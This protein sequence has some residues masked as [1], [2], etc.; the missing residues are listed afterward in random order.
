MCVVSEIL[1]DGYKGNL[2]TIRELQLICSLSVQEAAAACLVSPETFRRWRCDR[3][4]NPT[5]VRLMA[6]LGG[7]VPWAGWEGWEMHSGLLFP[8]GYSRHGIGPGDIMALPLLYQLLDL[9]RCEV[10][11]SDSV[12]RGKTVSG[13]CRSL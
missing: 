8:P 12:P 7:Y 11:V 9:R 2:S 1:R 4:P 13:K 3:R 5:A 10:R 6:V